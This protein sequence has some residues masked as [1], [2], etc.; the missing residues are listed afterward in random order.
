VGDILPLPPFSN[1]VEEVLA[2]NPASYSIPSLNKLSLVCAFMMTSPATATDQPFSP[3]E[4]GRNLFFSPLIRS[5]A[6]PW[7][8]IRCWSVGPLAS[9]SDF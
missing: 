8:V 4:A 7:S 9:Y 5:S 2:L 6:G 3:F 1:P